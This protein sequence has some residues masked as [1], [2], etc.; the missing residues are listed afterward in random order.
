MLLFCSKK[1]TTL[2]GGSSKQNSRP[3]TDYSRYNCNGGESLERVMSSKRLKE[4]DWGNSTEFVRGWLVNASRIKCVHSVANSENIFA[5]IF[6]SRK[7][8]KV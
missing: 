6:G 4:N 2:T 1:A 8:V 3:M 5:K 7:A